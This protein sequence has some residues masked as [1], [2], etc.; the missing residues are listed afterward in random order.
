MIPAHTLA[1]D[2]KL[3]PDRHGIY[4]IL[5]RAAIPVLDM[6]GYYEVAQSCH[7]FI[8]MEPV[9]YIGSARSSS[10]RQRAGHHLFGDARKSTFRQSLGIALSSRLNLRPIVA[11][12]QAGF[13]FGNGEAVLSAWIHQHLS[14]TFEIN[15]DPIARERTLMKS[16]HPPFNI[17]EREWDPFARHLSARRQ[18]ITRSGNQPAA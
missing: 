6:L 10:V 3:F 8:G 2:L 9:L 12:G 13:H 16:D 15:D 11:A 7:S 18:A 17:K 1:A 4:A 14:L 5:G